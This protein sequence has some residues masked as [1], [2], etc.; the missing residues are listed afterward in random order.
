[1]KRIYL[2]M[3]I[4]LAGC[5]GFL[6]IDP[7]KD[8][9]TPT[10][11]F[12]SDDAAIAA[13]TGIY[14]RMAGNSA[15]FASGGIRSI[16]LLAGLSS[17]ELVSFNNSTT[18]FFDNALTPSN[19]TVQAYLW[20]EPYQYIYTAN[21][22]LENL[23]G[24]PGVSAAVNKQL[25]GEALTIRAF[26]YFYLV[27]LFGDVPLHL[28]TQYEVNNSAT[29]LGADK[30][31]EQIVSDLVEASALLGENYVDNGRGRPNKWVA[32]ALL[33]RVYLFKNDWENAVKTASEVI[34]QSQLYLLT[35]LSDVFLANSREAI[36]QL[37]PVIPGINTQEAGVFIVNGT[38]QE[39]AIDS[40][41]LSIFEKG[42]QRKHIWIAR[43]SS[44]AGSFYFPYKYKIASNEQ[45]L[46]SS[47]VIRLA[48]LYLIRAEANF[49]INQFTLVVADINKIRVRAGLDE[50]VISEGE[51]LRSEIET[52]RRIELFSEWGHRWLDLKRWG[53]ADAVLAP[54]KKQNWQS[55]DALYPIPLAELSANPRI[56]QNPGY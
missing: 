45:I 2:L 13:L 26:C 1:M 18:D 27:N 9:I 42:D 55:I 7:P 12:E 5:T 22:V 51:Q 14:A 40:S 3:I 6:E 25:R 54:V 20:K 39:A 41:M 36:W 49:Q 48:E 43:A 11:V 53:R 33:S 44:E 46:E 8:Q 19:G 21:S 31:Y 28:S 35:D 52:Q 38:P 34:D 37:M 30:V 29:R 56:T 15:G 10:A 50:I 4:G 23:H 16:T 32:K 24:A 17:D 47:M